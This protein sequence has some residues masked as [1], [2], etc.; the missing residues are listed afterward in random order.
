[1][2]AI[3]IRTILYNVVRHFIKNPEDQKDVCQ[4][5]CRNVILSHSRYHEE[6]HSLAWVSTIARNTSLDFLRK[7]QNAEKAL[8]SYQYY[9]DCNMVNS[10]KESM[11]CR[12]VL[13]RSVEELQSIPNPQKA[14]LVA[15]AYYSGESNK[16]NISRNF[17]ISPKSV[18]RIIN[19]YN[20][21]LNKCADECM[22]PDTF[23]ELMEG[24]KKIFYNR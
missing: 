2:T 4:E 11:V 24:K 13:D 18:R 14:D 21:Y 5:S 22:N 17:N 7:K 20:V 1:M 16:I 23:Q 8:E 12:E 9:A 19:R 3:D 6:G 10:S 15:L